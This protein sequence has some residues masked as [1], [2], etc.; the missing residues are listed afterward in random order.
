MYCSPEL[1]SHLD[2]WALDLVPSS[3]LRDPR[4][5]LDQMPPGLQETQ[6][7]PKGF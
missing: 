4:A 2:T 6:F 5:T 1:G 3:A 7:S